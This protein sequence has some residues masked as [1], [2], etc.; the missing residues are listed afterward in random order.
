MGVVST[1]LRWETVFIVLLLEVML[2]LLATDCPTYN[3]IRAQVGF[4]PLSGLQFSF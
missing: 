4:S 3:K 1:D 2:V